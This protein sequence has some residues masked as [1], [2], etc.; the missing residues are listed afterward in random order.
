MIQSATTL[1]FLQ[2]EIAALQNCDIHPTAKLRGEPAQP[3][4][5]A[6]PRWPNVDLP[7]M[8]KRPV[9]VIIVSC[10]LIASGAVGLAYHFTEF[11]TSDKLEY[12]LI[13]L[14]RLLAIV[15][16][17]FMLQGRNWARWLAM[18]WITAHVVINV[19]HPFSQLAIHVV[20]FAAFTFVL[21]RRNSREYFRGAGAA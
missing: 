11:R 19:F 9:L 20:V 8:K 3:W 13:M 17:A 21:F 1:I 16:G 18:A 6:T 2:Y 12:G 7:A 15:A 14:V 10:V 5:R 4:S